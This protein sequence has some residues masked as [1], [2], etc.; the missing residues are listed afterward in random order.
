MS[1]K[2]ILSS[3]MAFVMLMLIIPQAAL[4]EEYVSLKE[5]ASANGYE[6]FWYE[7]SETVNV[8]SASYILSFQNGNNIV[9]YKT[10]LDDQ[11]T[12]TLNY[13]ARLEGIDTLYVSKLDAQTKLIKYFP[14]TPDNSI[15]A[16]VTALSDLADEP[17]DWAVSEINTAINNGLVTAN[18][19]KDYKADITREYFCELVVK[20][21]E[22]I[23]GD[24]VYAGSNPFDDTNNT[25]VIKAYE[26]GIVNGVSDDEF[27]PENKITRQE[28]CTMLVRAIGAMYENIDLNDYTRHSF[29][30]S[31]I[32]ASWAMDSVQ[33]A[34]DNEIMQGVGDNKIDPLGYA[35]CEQAVLLVNRIYENRKSFEERNEK[36]EAVIETLKTLEFDDDSEVKSVSVSFA[37]GSDASGVRIR[38]IDEDD[39]I[40]TTTGIKG[41]A[42]NITSREDFDKATISF[43][44]NPNGLGS[45]NPNDLAVAWYNTDLERIEVLE[46]KVNTSENTVSIE[47]TH[48]SEYVLVDSK[49]WYEVWQRGQMI[50]RETDDDGNYSSRFNV[51]LV[52]DCSGSMDSN[53]RL[54]NAKQCTYDFIHKLS[55]E[56]R[57]SVIQFADNAKTVVH[58]TEVRNA[59]MSEI[60]SA[61]MNIYDGGGTSFNAALTECSNTLDLSNA[62]YNNII[63]FLSDGG[64]TVSDSLLQTLNNNNVRIASVALGNGS[65]TAMMQKLSDQT[66]GQYVY[67]E[68]SSDLEMIY[69]AIQGSLIGVDATDTDGDGIPDIIETTGMKTRYGSVIRTDPNKWDTDGDG[70]S[71]G[72]EMGKLIE[73]DEVTEMDR[74]NGITQCVYFE[75]LSNPAEGYISEP[76]QSEVDFTLTATDI[77]TNGDA[78]LS[79]DISVKLVAARNI[80]IDFIV[81]DCIDYSMTYT[82]F[83]STFHS[84]SSA[85]K[86]LL[87]IGDYEAN[88]TLSCMTLKKGHACNNSHVITLKMTGDNFDEV[89]HTVTLKSKS[90]EELRDEVQI[91]V[92]NFNSCV[93][94]FAE[95]VSDVADND[96]KDRKNEHKEKAKAAVDSINLDTALWPKHEAG[97]IKKCVKDALFDYYLANA[98]SEKDSKQYYESISAS[99]FSDGG[100]SAMVKIID[101]S[102]NMITDI[103]TPTT[104]KE[105]E[106]EYDKDHKYKIRIVGLDAYGFL[107]IDV[108]GNSYFVPNPDN[109]LLLS[110]ERAMAAYLEELYSIYSSSVEG[111]VKEVA[112]E[113]TTIFKEPT[114]GLFS[115]KKPAFSD[116]VKQYLSDKGLG[117]VDQTIG[118]CIDVYNK[119][120]TWYDRLEKLSSK[121]IEEECEG[122]QELFDEMS[123]YIGDFDSM[124]QEPDTGSVTLVKYLQKKVK[125]K[126]EELV[127][128]MYSYKKFV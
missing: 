101:G 69:S 116:Q 41:R 100:I 87:T 114:G 68:D 31:S 59:N 82:E 109:D 99:D 28:I 76:D 120:R 70:L 15:D 53:N 84:G 125:S 79:L 25:E 22:K 16:D 52:V 91:A 13:D 46:S 7:D 95:S 55:E 24:N 64:S 5:L 29:A 113:I 34:Y 81:D 110:A 128:S 121:D 86:Q 73:T 26:L 36:S 58:S 124:V 47:T 118:Y 123:K 89:Q 112:K 115:P 66:N 6:Y 111:A 45:S 94:E 48:F 51:Q 35:T 23:T 33:F 90:Q 96:L 71:D 98:L 39:L 83:L 104:G 102:E 62:D 74:K 49:E 18:V 77:N 17:S 30:D 32:I 2:R 85:Y 106:Y 63:V 75:Y 3:F 21:Y 117:N 9:G 107:R 43:E 105:L 20:L 57:F 108:D 78:E 44:Y 42:V 97:P 122:L 80:Y 12:I 38:E 65:D 60:E 27:A 4:A 61:I 56:D 127:K 119:A 8:R 88:I 37:D 72:E 19:Q 10:V 103:L 11:G 14:N 40:N 67:A 126:L 54:P 50:V 92:R 93:T 1:V